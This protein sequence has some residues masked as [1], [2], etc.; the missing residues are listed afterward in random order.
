MVKKTE[1]ALMVNA[2]ALKRRLVSHNLFQA[3]T[4]LRHTV[5]RRATDI[6]K[7][8]L[9]LPLKELNTLSSVTSVD[10]FETGP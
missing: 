10:F 1:Y 4:S 9:S 7:P 3:A 6:N 2:F 8:H 5:G